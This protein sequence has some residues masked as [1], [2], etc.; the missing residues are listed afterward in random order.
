MKLL[1]KD[2]NASAYAG[3]NIFIRAEEMLLIEAEAKARL[4]QYSDARN[5]LKELM[6]VRLNTTGQTS[7]ATYLDGLANANTLPTLTTTDPTNVLEEVLI[8]RRIELWGEIGRIKD[9]LRLKQGYTRDYP[10]SNHVDKLVSYNTG[11]ES[12]AFIFK[13]PQAEFDGNRN[14]T[15][16]EQNPVN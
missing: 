13:I 15:S 3:D 11:A 12:W 5:L 8:Q 4:G 6:A 14:I 7:Y 2:I 1:I 9:I 10:G 16:A